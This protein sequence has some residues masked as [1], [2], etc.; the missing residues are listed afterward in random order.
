M[1]GWKS[2]DFGHGRAWRLDWIEVCVSYRRYSSGLTR[3]IRFTGAGVQVTRALLANEEAPAE[4]IDAMDMICRKA[5]TQDCRIWIDAESQAIQKAIDTWTIDLMRKYNREKV[6]VSNT[7]QTYL[8]SSRANLEHHVALAS[9]EGWGLGLKVVRG[10]YIGSEART[11]IHGTKEDTDRSYDGT[12]HDVL[13]G[14]NLGIPRERLP[15]MGL[16]VAGHNPESISKAFDLVRR[17][18]VEGELTTVPDFGQLQGM[19]DVVGCE[20]LQR[21]ETIAQESNANAAIPKMYKCIHWG[22]LQECMQ[23]LLRRA[24]ENSSGTDRMRDGIAAYKTELRRRF[25]SALTGK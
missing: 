12:I 22:S 14:T 2:K 23:Y 5:A 18:D 4:L 13:S 6:L 20:F 1:A 10:A 21:R 7:L 25:L 15:K 3:V 8:K 16:F 19:G 11:L 9:K 17:L 24:V